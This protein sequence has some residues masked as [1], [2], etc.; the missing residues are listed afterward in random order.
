ML[1][2]QQRAALAALRASLGPDSVSL[3]GVDE[4]TRELGGGLLELQRSVMSGVRDPGVAEP[5]ARVTH[6]TADIAW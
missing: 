3:V 1:S 5:W 4:V 6:D 2:G